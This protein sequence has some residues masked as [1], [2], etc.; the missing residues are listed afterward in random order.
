MAEIDSRVRILTGALMDRG[1]SWLAAE[2]IDTIEGGQL[3][4]DDLDHSVSAQRAAL[5]GRIRMK[6]GS[7]STPVSLPPKTEPLSLCQWEGLA[8][9]GSGIRTRSV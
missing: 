2:I 5:N 6:V 9:L 7:S 8:W 4:S 3:S 1:F